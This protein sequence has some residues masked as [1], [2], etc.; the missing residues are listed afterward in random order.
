MT[1]KLE[2]RRKEERSDQYPEYGN[3]ISRHCFSGSLSIA[4]STRTH[5]SSKDMP[6]DIGGGDSK[7]IIRDLQIN[8][9]KSLIKYDFTVMVK[10]YMRV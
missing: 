6:S 4:V 8:K 1:G 5:S 10:Q 2:F 7:I 9:N 3:Y